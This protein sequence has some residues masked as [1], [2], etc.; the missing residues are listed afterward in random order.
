LIAFAYLT[1]NGD[2]HGKNVSLR[3]TPSGRVEMT[4]AYD[5]VTTLPYGDP[6][7]AL[8]LE[9]REDGL[10]RKTFVA[11]GERFGV[12]AEATRSILDELARAIEPCLADLGQIGFDPRETRHLA[13]TMKKRLRDLAA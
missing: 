12:R 13:S 10:K 2:L 7:M 8:A 4:E 11:F 1:C 6:N 5:L 3:T 9:D